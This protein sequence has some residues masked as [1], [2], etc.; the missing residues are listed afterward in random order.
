MSPASSIHPNCRVRH[1]SNEL[2]ATASSRRTVD[3]LN[4]ELLAVWVCVAL[5]FAALVF[6]VYVIW[7]KCN[8]P[9][10]V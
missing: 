2:Y 5:S 9:S 6:A 4:W 10:P 7:A 3:P 1:K 8:G